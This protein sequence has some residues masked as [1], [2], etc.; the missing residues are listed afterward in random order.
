[1]IRSFLAVLLLLAACADIPDDA[2]DAAPELEKSEQAFTAA[3]FPSSVIVRPNLNSTFWS[4]PSIT[5]TYRQLVWG[6]ADYRIPTGSELAVNAK[7]TGGT[8]VASGLG[9]KCNGVQFTC[10]T[11][12]FATPQYVL[13]N[14]NYYN[15]WPTA[16]ST[17]TVFTSSTNPPT[18]IVNPWFV[19]GQ[20]QLKCLYTAPNAFVTL[21]HN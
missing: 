12:S 11:L 16:Q 19:S 20:W 2:P 21:S 8:C 6:L 1:M 9:F 17:W 14:G 5:L 13:Y 15:W 4:D 7:F 3:D 10:P 18:S